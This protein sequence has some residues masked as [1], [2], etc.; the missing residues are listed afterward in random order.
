MHGW[1]TRRGAIRMRPHDTGCPMTTTLDSDDRVSAEP[2]PA[3]AD[4]AR[5]ARAI[6]TPSGTGSMVWRVWGAQHPGGPRPLVLLHGGSGSWR[7]WCRNVEFFS[8]DRMLLVPDLPGLGE[9]AM[10]DEPVGPDS[11]AI[12]LSRGLDALLPDAARYDLAGFSFGAN[13]AGHL[14]LRDPDRCAMLVLV[15]AASLGLIRS[16]TDLLKVRDKDGAERMDAHRFNLATLMFADASR[17][18]DVALAIQEWNTRH[19][20]LKSRQFAGTD[21]LLQ[22][23]R[24]GR[25]PLGVIYGARDAICYPHVDQRLDLLRATRPG[26]DARTVADAGH[27]VAYEQAAAF[28]ATLADML[29]RAP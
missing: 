27:W 8:R 3:L 2:H 17:I 25:G 11:C 28:D 12:A 24:R 26:A 9:S 14:A 15:G 7:H 5:A 18:D 1:T 6:R 16:R 29:A 21:S 4:L 19:A 22:A 23:V 20:R 10:P 13:C